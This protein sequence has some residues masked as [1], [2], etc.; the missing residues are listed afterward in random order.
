[1][2]AGTHLDASTQASL[3]ALSSAVQDA[4]TNGVPDTEVDKLAVSIKQKIESQLVS[5]RGTSADLAEKVL[6]IINNK[7]W[8]E[9]PAPKDLGM[10]LTRINEVSEALSQVVDNVMT[11]IGEIYRI[12]SELS[13]QILLQNRNAQVL[14]NET[15]VKEAK[16]ANQD[17]ERA[18][19]TS[20]GAELASSVAQFATATATLK[21]ATQ[22]LGKIKDSVQSSKDA[23]A[24]TV[25][26]DA[27]DTGSLI[28]L[29]EKADTTAQKLA[30]IDKK[31]ENIPHTDSNHGK[32]TAARAEAARLHAKA[33]RELE[34][35]NH[36]V[37][38]KQAD[39]MNSRLLADAR[40]QINRAK[41]EII[42]ATIN[43]VSAALKLTSSL[44]NL[45]A[46]KHDINKTLSEKAYQ[47]SQEV[48]STARESLRALQN[49]LQAIEQV[50]SNMNSVMARNSA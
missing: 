4:K 19:W 10:T 30:V 22:S 35:A 33:N 42:G 24:M 14:S 34:L 29:K 45:E 11:D 9:L 49:S 18:A 21:G 3:L 37:E 6:Q 12:L 31:L 8:A 27:K 39:S 26:K 41:G 32:L 38:Q 1:M 44:L 43:S 25:G 5:L 48:V 23:Y 2:R 50:L 17:R 13:S 15:S 40:M 46:D 28:S 7:Q 20:F 36:Q 16:N 47:A